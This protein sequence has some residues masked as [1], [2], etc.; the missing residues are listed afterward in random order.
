MKL[1]LSVCKSNP[2]RGTKFKCEK[3]NE[4]FAR[5]SDLKRHLNSKR[6]CS[7][8]KSTEPHNCPNCHKS[9]P[10]RNSLK[11]HLKSC[12]FVNMS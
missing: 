12:T 5:E 8:P 6:D 7:A 10:N 11:V 9:M 1:H 3:C 2:D 4:F